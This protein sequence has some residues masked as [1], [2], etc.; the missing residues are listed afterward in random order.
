MPGFCAPTW[1]ERARRAVARTSIRGNLHLPQGQGLAKAEGTQPGV[2]S[3]W[4]AV[5]RSTVPPST[6]AGS[7]RTP[8]NLPDALAL[9]RRSC[10]SALGASPVGCGLTPARCLL[11]IFRQ[12][13]Q[14]QD[15]WRSDQ[16]TDGV[17]RWCEME[18]RQGA[19]GE[20]ELP[21]TSVARTAR[22]TIRPERSRLRP[23]RAGLK[24]STA[25]W[26]SA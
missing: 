21:W 17:R 12:S 19:S 15:A 4:P 2:I 11:L 7:C 13:V 16:M 6:T 14:I 25:C 26:W 18:A 5:R 1:P 8:T 24:S 23:P 22:R 3:P 9:S 20:G 10:W